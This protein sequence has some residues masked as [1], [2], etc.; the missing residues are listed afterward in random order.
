MEEGRS[1]RDVRKGWDKGNVRKRAGYVHWWG[2]RDGCR[3]AMERTESEKVAKKMNLIEQYRME[4]ERE[5]K[6]AEEEE[7]K[8]LRKEL[9]PK[10]QPMPYFDRPFIPRR[11]MKQPTMPK[12]P[13]FHLPQHKKAKSLV[14]LDDLYT[15]L[16]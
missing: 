1:Q 11:S 16:E 10:A 2:R 8:R 3:V 4:R 12:Q 6:L 15:Q 9:V 7:I 5:Q 14:S 13:N